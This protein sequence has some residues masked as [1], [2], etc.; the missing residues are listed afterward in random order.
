MKFM[1]L[2]CFITISYICN[3]QEKISGIGK[4]KLRE[5]TISIIEDLSKELKSKVVAVNNFNDYYDLKR[6]PKN[7]IL[8]LLPDT[9]T[10]NNSPSYATEYPGYRVFYMPSYE[11]SNIK[12]KDVV[13]LF[14]NNVLVELHCDY[15]RELN[16]AIELKYGTPKKENTE[17][18]VNCTFV[19]SGNKITYKDETF[20]S[21]WINGDIT[22]TSSIRRYYDSSCKESILAYSS[23][24]IEGYHDQ[25]NAWDKKAIE[26]RRLREKE[27]KKS[28]LTD[29]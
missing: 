16:E 26:K 21:L 15:S 17:K 10:K 7:K 25:R 11:I 29:F 24:E 22:W 5:T 27:N 4:F 14:L 6:K 3:A 9:T 2:L 12:I 13:L 19:N 18:D 8:E 28:S 1:L 23:L 20:R